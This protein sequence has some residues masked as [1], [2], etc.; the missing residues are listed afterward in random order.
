GYFEGRIFAHA[1]QWLAAWGLMVCALLLMR[2]LMPA[3]LW[4]YHGA[5]H[6]AIGAYERYGRLATTA[7]AQ[8]VTR[9]H[10]RCGT[11]AVFL[12]MLFAPVIAAHGLS[13]P[14][15]LVSAEVIRFAVVRFPKSKMTRVLVSGGR[16][17]QRTV[18]TTEPSLEELA[19][20]CR[21]VEACIARQ[22]GVEA[23]AAVTA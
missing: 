9:I 19:V 6:K 18:T 20:G 11:N 2:L 22:R 3:A 1:P 23:L 12:V 5:E 15:V 10:D 17:L 16:F 21:A 14:A 4:R 13:L 7:E 8:P